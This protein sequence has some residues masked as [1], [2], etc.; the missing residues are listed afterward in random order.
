[1]HV[2]THVYAQV[3]KHACTRFGTDIRNTPT[4]PLP[5]ADGWG[6]Q[7]DETHSYG[8]Y[9]CGPCSYGL[10]DY[11]LHSYGLYSYGPQHDK[12]RVYTRYNVHISRHVL[13]RCLPVPAV[14]TAVLGECHARRSPGLY[15]PSPTACLPRGY[16]RAGTQDDGLDAS[17]PGGDMQ[18]HA[19]HRHVYTSVETRVQKTWCLLPPVE[20]RRSATWPA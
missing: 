20:S 9:S 1:M 13:R 19:R 17:S 8:I 4:H 10:S 15:R 18:W 7:H 2:C 14:L 16:R 3:C 5:V 12:T 6:P 11:G